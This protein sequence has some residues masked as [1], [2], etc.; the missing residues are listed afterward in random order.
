MPL[1]INIIKKR[2]YAYLVELKGSIDTAT[3]GELKKELQEILD[4]KAKAVIMNMADVEYISS[5]G[6]GVIVWLQTEL[7]RNNANFS[8]TN[9]QPAVKKVL[10]IMKL[11]PII[12]IL[13]DVEEADAY[14]NE[15]M[16]EELEQEKP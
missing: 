10:D 9:L 1:E 13:E 15:I 4:V 2:D 3:H 8:M 14:I 5:V 11:I 7:Q 16:E 12:D 6:I